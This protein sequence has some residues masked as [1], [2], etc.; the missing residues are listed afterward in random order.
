VAKL[1]GAYKADLTAVLTPHKIKFKHK[2]SD[3]IERLTFDVRLPDAITSISFEFA[4]LIDNK[5]VV[6]NY[7]FIKAPK[8]KTPKKVDYTFANLTKDS[9][10]TGISPTSI[11]KI[12]EVQK[13]KAEEG[14]IIAFSSLEDQ[15][16]AYVSVLKDNLSTLMEAAQAFS[17]AN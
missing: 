7:A 4:Y 15:M 16:G 6:L 17:E 1:L 3:F 12:I 10:L 8:K 5:S 2:S 9:L 11:T 14:H 13:Y